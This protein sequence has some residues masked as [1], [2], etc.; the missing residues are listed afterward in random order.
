MLHL[1]KNKAGV[2]LIEVTIG[3]LIFSIAAVGLFSTFQAQRITTEQTEKR[4]E[5]AYVAR[6][7]LEDLRTKVDP[8]NWN[9]GGALAVGSHTPPSITGS[10]PSNIQYTVTYNVITEPDPGIR[11]VDLTVSW[12]EPTP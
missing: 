6:Q 11:R 1:S 2:S 7:V 4:L 3:A 8:A 12:N 9:F 10:P 5:A